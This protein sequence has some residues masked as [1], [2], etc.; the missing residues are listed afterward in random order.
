MPD[1]RDDGT[2]SHELRAILDAELDS[3]PPRFRTPLIL[4]DIEG[5]THEQAAIELRCPV[6]T[7]KSRLA[8][9]RERLR[10]R[11]IRRGFATSLLAHSPWFAHDPM[12][13]VPVKL[14]GQTV[15]AA[16][17]LATRAR[18]LPV[19]SPPERFSLPKGCSERWP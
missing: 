4:C 7:V 16:T 9:A 17:Q 3:L 1:Q 10:S 6:G 14:L 2:Q 11:L 18:S 15:R 5:Q 8:Q 19:Q 13:A 12:S